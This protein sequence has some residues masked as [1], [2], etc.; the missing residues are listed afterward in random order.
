MQHDHGKFSFWSFVL[1]YGWRLTGILSLTIFLSLLAMLPPLIS[2]A[3]ID[4][5]LTQGQHSL[6]F[7]LGL[8]ML[9]IPLVVATCS[10]LQTTGIAVVGQRFVFDIRNAL[11]RHLLDLSMRFYGNHSSGKLVNR[12]MGDSGTVQQ[13]ITAQTISIASDLVCAAFAVSAIFFISWRIGLLVALIVF[14][15]VLNFRSNISRIRR[16]TW[17]YQAAFDRLSGGV[18]NRL[19]TAV[20]V[21]T[22]GTEGREQVEFQGGLDQSMGLVREASMAGN[23]FWMNT[24]LIQQCGNSAIF[25]L[26]CFM[27][28]RDQISYGDVV[29]LTAYSMQLLWPVVR[30]SEVAKQFQDVG[31]AVERLTELF[32]EVPEISDAPG[33]VPLPECRGEIEF[34]NVVFEYQPGNPVIQDFTLHVKPGMTVALIGPTGC[35]KST[36]L[37]LVMRYF[38]IVK[39]SL[40]IDGIEVR[41]IQLNSLRRQFGIVLQEPLLFSVSVA[42]NIRYARPQA[43]LDEVMAAAKVAEIHDFIMTLPDAYATEIGSDGL[44]L[45]VGQ[46]QRITI[47]RAVLAEPAILIMDEATSSLD[48][49]SEKAIQAAMERVLEHRTCLV[50][51]HRLSTIRNADIIVLLKDG[52]IREAGSHDELMN[53][54]GGHYR[55]LYQQHMGKAV[56]EE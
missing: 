7:S 18:Q 15:F 31:V 29:A 45:S 34:R 40:K 25:F 49:D 50:V 43:S 5:V 33:A 37:S 54:A 52:M 56:L 36:I 42:E 47:A 12:L 39:G 48:S 11:Y 46:K 41:E 38:D 55:Q 22:Y 6:L 17:G 3:I 21:K 14:F 32:T 28:L 8:A 20:A 26:G 51:A 9:S 4:R 16:A 1:P 35:G 27:V 44:E 23:T 24:H 19:N 30:F 10:F 53:L 2:R 13:S